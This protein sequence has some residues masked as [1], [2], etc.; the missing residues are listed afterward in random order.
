MSHLFHPTILREYDIRGIVGET[1]SAEDALHIGKAFGT[2]IVE[3]GGSVAYTCRDGRLSS[4]ELEQ[5][6][7]DGL[8]SCGIT[9]RRLG[10]GPT[11]MLYYA[12]TAMQA[13]A[14]IMITGSHNPPSHNG[15]KMIMKGRPFF[16]DDIKKIGTLAESGAYAT[17]E[18]YQ[19]FVDMRA[20]YVERLAQDYNGDQPLKVVWDAGNGA[21]GDVLR[22]LTAILPGQHI[23]LYD[24]IDG[25]FPNHHP[26]PTEPENLDD[27][28]AKV[29]SEDA[30]LGIAFDGDGDRLGVVDGNGR[31]MWGDQ[32]MVL[33]AE[34]VLADE[35]GSTII[36]DVKASQTLFDAIAEMG[37][38]PLM[39]KTGH[40]LIKSKM[41]ETAAPLAG[42]MS[43]HIFFQHRYYGFD[44]A[45]YAAVRFLS[46]VASFK[47][48]TLADR[49]DRM[50]RLFNTPELRFDCAD[51]KKF[52]IMEKVKFRLEKTGAEVDTTDGVRVKAEGGWWL[53]RAS[54]TQAVLVARC[55][56]GSAEAL[57]RLKDQLKSHLT[58]CG[59]TVP[60][61]L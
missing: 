52:S 30:D 18:G 49:F 58:A 2:C 9:V 36:A 60:E 35:P 47:G 14:G 26:D 4:E 31:I 17:G 11:P 10:L 24:E 51:E 43:G 20:S 61:G 8:A 38:K 55:E 50:P 40:S 23:L 28:M 39:W 41:A 16:G 45:L 3:N 54:N 27:L 6:V 53:L 1:L 44:D 21:T 12:A 29:A 46:I 25:H 42:E 15:F 19:D 32:L 59:L 5:A 22:R 37:G 13:D 57:E 34:N 7:A 56:A 33:F 48:E